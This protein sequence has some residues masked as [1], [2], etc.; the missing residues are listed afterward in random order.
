MKQSIPTRLFLFLILALLLWLGVRYFLPILTPFLLAGA[1][2]LLAEPL[3]R[4]LDQRLH[5]KR[6]FASAI[7]VGVSLLVTLALVVGLCA[8]LVRQLGNLSGI[9]PDLADSAMSGLDSMEQFCLSLSRKAPDSLRPALTRGIENLFSDGSVI[10]DRLSITFFQFASGL[11]SQIPDS[12]LGF[13][14]WI[15]ASFMLSAKLP[16]IRAYLSR[17]M[18]ETWH[19][20]Y[21]PALK[22]LRK[23][24]F[25]WLLAQLKL[26]SITFLILCVG[27]FLLRIPLAPLW[28][29]LISLVDALPVLGTGTV[30]IPWSVI[31]FLQGNTPQALGILG[32]YAT[33][34]LTRT[35][36]E[37]KLVGKQLGL[38]PLVTLFAMYAG[39][40]LWGIGGMLLSPLL[41][42]TV[43]QTVR[44][45][46]S[47]QQKSP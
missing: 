28:A 17:R 7:G 8:L 43:S 39:Y 5:L 26:I 42:I 10:L 47:G 22:T 20:R 46:S 4:C 23:N 24:L 13:G 21:L 16:Q 2:A 45:F 30:L 34:M 32:L 25:G 35:A 3:V 37:P 15:L 27:F 11:F 6:G 36:L 40:R 29:F 41:A 18:P 38:D 33:A 12:A 31:C 1:L 14:T 44:N 19:S 9:L